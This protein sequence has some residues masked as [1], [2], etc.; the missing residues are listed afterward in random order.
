MREDV[1]RGDI[2]FVVGGMATGSEQDADRPAVIVS[3]DTGNRFA[4]VV[5]LV[6]L[7]TQRKGGLPTHVYIGSAERPSTALCEQIVT[8]CKSRLA[9]RMGHVTDEEMKN[10]DKALTR[11]LG[12]PKGEYT[13]Q[14]IIKTPFGEMNFDMAQEKAA[15]LM[16]MAFQY[17]AGQKPVPETPP[18][19]PP[20]AQEPRKAPAPINKPQSRVERLF[21][22]FKR[23]SA[24]K[25]TAPP[26]A[27][28]EEYKG[29]LL[30]KCENC[31][32]VKGFC[33][34]HPIS[35][36]RC[37][38]GAVTKL[39]GLKCAH[40]KCGKCGSSFT[41]KTNIDSE[42]FDYPCLHC[43]SPVDLALNKRGD[44]YV[45]ITD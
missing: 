22:D 37:D 38:C 32:K 21:G 8:V 24:G 34:K 29:F 36:H 15:E 28:P 6:Y 11:S 41:Y 7:T 4:P 27:E 12:I 1:R 3:N 30:L 10:I 2:Y 17:A 18:L 31:G 26:P 40:L 23:E 16:Q 45:T 13:M 44:T 20:V 9:R 14:V 35:E 25:A 43:G 39:R 19:P 5:E 33:A 42:V